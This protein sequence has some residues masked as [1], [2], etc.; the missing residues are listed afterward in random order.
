MRKIF[1]TSILISFII[2]LSFSQELQSVSK[3]WCHSIEMMERNFKLHPELKKQYDAFQANFNTKH[4]NK[5]NRVLNPA[6]TNYTIPVV[7]H[8]LHVNGAENIS[9]AQIENQIAILNRDFN[10]QNADTSVVIPPFKNIIGNAHITFALAKTDPN[11][12]CTNGIDRFYDTKTLSWEGNFPDYT[13]TWDPTQYLNFYVVKSIESGAAGYAYYPG[14][15]ST[16]SPMDAILILHS[17]V[18][19]IGTSNVNQSRAIT[20]EVGHWLNLQHTWGNTNNPGVACGDDDVIDTPETM[21]FVSCSTEL[22]SQICNPGISENYQNYMDYSYCS[23]MFTNDQVD[24]MTD[25]L[26][27]TASGRNNLSTTS[28]LIATGINPLAQCPPTALFKSDKQMICVGQTITF[29]DQSN[30]GIPDSW[31]WEFEGGTPNISSVQNPTVTY[32]SPG[33]YSVQLVSSNTIGSSNPAIKIGYITVLPSPISTS[34]IEGFETSTL[35]NATWSVKNLSGS[36]IT[37]QQTN[38][39]A[40]SGSKSAYVSEDVNPSSSIDL[41]SPTYNFSAMPNLALTLKWAG[42]ERNTTTTSYDAFSVYFSTNCGVSWTPKLVRNIRSTTAGVSGVMDGGFYPTPA[43]F[44]QEVISISSLSSATN[45][46]FR[47]RLVTESGSSNNFYIDDINLSTTTS[48]KNNNAALSNL[49]L[50]PN[51]ANEKVFL[52]FDLTDHKNIEIII[53]DVLG[54]SVKKLSS[55]NYNSGYNQ[56]EIPVSDLSKGIYFL[57]MNVNGQITTNKIV[58]D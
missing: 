16:G 41:Y 31:A 47:L 21:G 43:Q 55:Q 17:Y 38:L 45:I 52:N 19:S 23:R 40:A 53:Y 32:N 37:W 5:N 4:K 2:N 39:S 54:K 44:N 28:N 8:V 13:Y 35:P 25:A 6:I 9:D 22:S 18:G 11:G 42:A 57:S 50:Y 36:G 26:D 46:L 7:F 14:S 33:T 3:T 20:H 10:S 29:T 12:N 58:I 51:P 49:S 24:R 30:V 34:L 48:I 15:L 56:I 1:F 27:A